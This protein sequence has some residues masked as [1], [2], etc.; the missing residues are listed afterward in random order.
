MTDDVEPSG[1]LT[2]RVFGYVDVMQRL[3][4][5]IR[6]TDDWGPL[7]EFVAVDCL[8]KAIVAEITHE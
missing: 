5:T 7:A 1:P 8:T 3:V 4:P 6:A 2:R